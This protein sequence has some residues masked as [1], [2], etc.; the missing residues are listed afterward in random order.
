MQTV[1]ST[2]TPYSNESNC[3]EVIR[4]SS[5]SLYLSHLKRF[6]DYLIRFTLNAKAER[7][8]SPKG[9]TTCLFI[10]T[11][12]LLIANVILGYVRISHDR[13]YSLGSL[14]YFDMRFNIPFYFS[15]A[16]LLLNL[17][18]IY[19]IVKAKSLAPAQLL[20]WKTLGIV[21]IVFT[22]DEALY[23]H[24]FLKMSTFGTIASYDQK[25]PS[26]YLWVVPYV[27][28][29][30]F[31]MLK[32]KQYAHAIPYYLGKRI[33]LASILF[34]FGAVFMEFLGTYY[35]VM[36]KEAD[37]WLMLIK[38]GEGLFQMIGSVVFIYIFSVYY[39]SLIIKG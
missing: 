31:L 30:G 4:I 15:I 9:L 10:I 38:T 2:R 22:I 1:A 21:F 14:F 33:L 35:S 18:F 34:L 6:Y 20:F 13:S 24:F 5:V 32:L 26:H 8:L 12:I 16:L 7:I 27:L 29:F 3:I 11:L 23:L 19:K 37:L 28:V 36:H 39:R 17:Y 25:A